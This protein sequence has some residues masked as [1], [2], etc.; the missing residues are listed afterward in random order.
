TNVDI[1]QRHNLLNV[2]L[3]GAGLW[4][5]AYSVSQTNL[6]R[7][8]SVS[9]IQEA[10]TTLWINIIG[11]FFI[12]VVIFLSGLAAFSVYANCDPIS[13]GLIDTKE[14]I[15]PYFVIDKMGFLWGVPGLFVAS[16]FSGSL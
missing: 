8:C 15:L 1:Y 3:L 7:V 14:Q 9:T 4:G 11:T 16:L 12:W 2:I 13:Q 10:R 5:N 6:Q